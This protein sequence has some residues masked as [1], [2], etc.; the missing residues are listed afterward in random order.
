MRTELELVIIAI[1]LIVAALVI[2]TIF[3]GGIRGVGDIAS[4]RS[5]CINS[6]RSSC[7]TTGFAP[8]NWNSKTIQTPEGDYKSCRDLVGEWAT[9][10]Q[11]NSQFK[12]YNWND[13]ICS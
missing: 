4:A 8:F 6:G 3:G 5:Q 2:L 10:C 1:M 9:C 13:N 12:N 11:Y 7:Q